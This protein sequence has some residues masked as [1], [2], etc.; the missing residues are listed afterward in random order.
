[1]GVAHPPVVGVSGMVGVLQCESL[2]P[3]RDP[4]LAP[5]SPRT[6]ELVTKPTLDPTLDRNL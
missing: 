1:M 5:V 4:V 3:P 6:P 2:P